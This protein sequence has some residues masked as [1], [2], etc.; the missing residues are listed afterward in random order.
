MCDSDSL[1]DILIE[2]KKLVDENKKK[3][4]LEKKLWRVSDFAEYLGV[5]KGHIYNLNSKKLVPS[6][7]KGKL[8]YFLPKE[9]FD[10]V[11]TGA[12]Q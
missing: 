6:H 11:L 8:L 1:F 7:K 3:E 9:I 5:S 4:L 2:V 10:W 12:T